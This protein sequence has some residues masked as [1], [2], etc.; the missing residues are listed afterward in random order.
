[1]TA[2]ALDRGVI[3]GSAVVLAIWV[4]IPFYLVTMSAL[5]PQANV[6]DYPKAL[7]PSSLS[8]TT[9]ELFLQ[10]GGVVPAMLNSLAVA[11]LTVVVGLVLGAPA[12]YALARFR[13]RG[14]AAFRAVVLVT[15]MF[16]IAILAIPLAAIFVRLGLYDNLISVALV[17]SAMALPFVILIVGGVLVALPRDLEEA[18]ETLGCG[19]WGAFRRVALPPAMPGLVAAAIFAFVI[20]WN[21]V[22]AA[23]I[24]TVRTRTLPAQVLA[25]LSTS[26]LALKFVAAF[27]M[28]L[29]A[30]VF[31]I[32]I[33]RYL[34]L[35][36]RP[37]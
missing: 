5:T 8:A 20:S 1:M 19:R 31:I 12:A 22:F 35:V 13:F 10:S 33:R 9:I 3:Y 4:L 16:P 6:S 26:P 28:V 11:S 2:R 36:W 30:V 23:S 24:L 29:P 27:F 32:L 34:R 37:R 7:F 18:A 15:K 17:H 25:S 21:E 14:R